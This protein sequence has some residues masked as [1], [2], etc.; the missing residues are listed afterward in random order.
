[1]PAAGR[2]GPARGDGAVWRRTVRPPRFWLAVPVLLALAACD[3]GQEGVVPFTPTSDQ[4]GGE[5]VVQGWLA[6][7]RPRPARPAP[8]AD[9]AGAG[10]PGLLAGAPRGTVFRGRV[11][12][13]AGRQ[14]R[15]RA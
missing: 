5:A 14:D 3:V 8:G 7:H 1:M 6:R 15:H 9:G 2:C 10:T 12:R 13:I 11:A 4:G